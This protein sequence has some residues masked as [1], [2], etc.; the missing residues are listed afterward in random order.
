M[1]GTR[2]RARAS[3]SSTAVLPEYPLIALRETVLF[4]RTTTPLL[5]GRE[6]LLLALE[7]AMDDKQMVVLVAYKDATEQEPTADQLHTIGTLVEVGRLLTLADGSSSLLATGVQRVKILEFVQHEPF[8]QVRVMP[9]F[10]PND[11]SAATEA[12]VRVV[13]GLFEDGAQLGGHVPDEV[14]T[15]AINADHAGALADVV[16]STLKLTIGQKQELLETL[17]PAARLQKVHVIL[18]KEIKVM[19]LEHKISD[20]VAEEMD[21]S[22]REYFLREQLRV[23][24][25]ELGE[26]GPYAG[27]YKELHDQLT[28]MQ[29]P[30]EVR[31]RAEKEL[32]RLAQM[33]PASPEIGIIRTYLDWISELPWSQ[34]SEDSIDMPHVGR[35]LNKNHFALPRVKERI[36][37]HIAVRKLAL[38]EMRTPVLCF[39]GP[40]GTGKTSLGKSIAEALGRKFVRVSLGGIRDEA[41]VR[42]HRRTYIG[43]MPGRII[44]TMRRAGTINPVFMLDEI[45]KIGADYRG[46]PSASLLEVL[47]PE[48]NF[49]FSDHYLDVPYD[50]SKVFFIC[51]ANWLDPI[52]WALHDRLEVIQFSGYTEHEKLRIAKSFLIDKQ[53]KEHGLKKL[54]FSDAALRT[55]IREYTYEAGVRNLEREVANICRKVARRVA[56]NRSAV[57]HVTPQLVT[58]F[59]G[60]PKY[61]FGVMEEEDQIGVAMG[62][63]WTAGGGDTMPIEVT[64]MDGK[65]SMQLTGQLGDMTQESAHAALSYARSHAREI[66]IAANFDRM[67]IHVH[68]PE[69]A[70]P[71]D[72]PSA[73]VTLAIALIS[74]LL[75]RPV[76]RDVGM[77]GEITLRG[78]ILPVGGLKEKALAAHRAGLKVLVVPHKNR[79]D[80]P[81]IPREVQRDVKLMFVKSMDEVLPIALVP[82]GHQPAQ[83][84]K[85]TSR[86]E[87]SLRRREAFRPAP[88]QP[89][90]QASP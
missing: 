56:E 39:V 28:Q 9:I 33:P 22:Q 44:Q 57:K 30:D 19:E 67:D 65:G 11:D 23:I 79:K 64:I 73:G 50:L 26:S 2:R 24:Q 82:E 71:K 47:D 16:A 53:L 12:L 81:E 3:R 59:L 74:A 43:A 37:E 17:D 15:A 5:I 60:P 46:D 75:R 18:A 72:G 27:E 68:F 77:T 78:R 85:T 31:R 87:R 21:K 55:L 62:M 83:A 58:K 8:H 4:P 49:A 69:G 35:V 20:R 89:A 76:R 88:D 29:L 45:D 13:R 52:P 86:R 70:V 10:E 32:E 61:E 42:G 36:V 7:E 48:Q 84:R 66:G 25:N 6:R 80:L 40:P 1:A 34:A 63:A 54:A 41:E 90:T 14:L 51:T 38:N